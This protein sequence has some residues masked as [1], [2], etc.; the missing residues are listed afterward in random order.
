MGCRLPSPAGKVRSGISEGTVAGRRC[1]G[2]DA[3]ETVIRRTAI[4][5][6]ESTSKAADMTSHS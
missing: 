6:P 1:N 4:E 5:R 3:P 2:E